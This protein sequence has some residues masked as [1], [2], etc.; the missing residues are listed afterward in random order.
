MEDKDRFYAY[1]LKHTSNTNDNDEN[2]LKAA[3]QVSNDL[4]KEIDAVK[5][6][7]SRIQDRYP[8]G[9]KEFTRTRV[10]LEK[11]LKSLK[12]DLSKIEK[13]RDQ[14]GTKLMNQKRSMQ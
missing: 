14:L 13:R 8:D 10:R 11:K 3:N 2:T 7:L 4:E 6:E 5:Q 9:V 12:A 1:F